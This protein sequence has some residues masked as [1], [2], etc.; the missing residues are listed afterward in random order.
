MKLRL[1]L[2]ASLLAS[3]N[4]V[5]ADTL[6]YIEATLSLDTSQY[7]SGDVLA[8][9][10]QVKFV[11][12]TSSKN[13]M[14]YSLTVLDKDDQAKAMDV[15]FLRSNVSIGT[16]NS[17]VSVTDANA[18][19]ILGCVEVA[20]DDYVDLANSQIVTKTGIGLV[21]REASTSGDVYVAAV[22]RSTGTYTAS[23]IALK[24][25]LVLSD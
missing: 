25:G 5:E 21:L 2:L 1:L 20:A 14:L 8:D 7:A 13:V 3:C 16:E 15:C 18:D 23:G 9:S 22:S 17:P 6:H 12:P 11:S 19:E 24:L 4:L 10:Q